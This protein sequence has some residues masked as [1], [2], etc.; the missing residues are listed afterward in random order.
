MLRFTVLLQIQAQ[1]S[2]HSNLSSKP[3]YITTQPLLKYEC[4]E[5]PNVIV[6][7][8]QSVF[9]RNFLNWHDFISISAWYLMMIRYVS[10]MYIVLFEM[11]K[12][13]IN[14]SFCG[15]VLL[16]SPAS[17]WCIEISYVRESYFKLMTSISLW[18]AKNSQ[19]A[20]KPKS[21]TTKW[22]EVNKIPAKNSKGKRSVKAVVGNNKKMV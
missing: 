22:R 19:L 7:F 11:L 6:A 5:L 1:K 9:C 8:S 21:F 20:K 17:F 3:G 4:F 10:C 14:V 13:N 12:K 2:L 15:C 16:K 18:I